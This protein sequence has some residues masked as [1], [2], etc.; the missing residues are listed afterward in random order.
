M[1]RA[2]PREILVAG[3]LAFM[4]YA[5][6]GYM[7]FDSVYQLGEARSGVF[8]DG[9][10]PAMAEL[11][12]LVDSVVAGPVGMLLIQSTCFLAGLY[13][14]FRRRMPARVSAFVA[15]GVLLFPP[16]TSLMAVIWKDSQ[17]T[18]FLVLGT[19]F[20]LDDNRR[21]KIAGLAFLVAGT[22]MRHNALVMT[23]PLVVMLFQWSAA[24]RFWKRHA[25]AL[26]AWIAVTGTAQMVSRA[27]TTEQR[28]IWVDSL[29]LCD[30]TSTLRYVPDTIP[31]A[32]LEAELAGT[33]VIP[34]HD[35]HVHARGQELG[36]PVDA[37]WNSAYAFFAIPKDEAERAAVTRAWRTIVF[38]HF[39]A[40][41]TY[42]LE[43]FRRVLGLIDIPLTSPV[44]NWFTDVQDP[45]GSGAKIGHDA[46]AGKL[47]NL[48]RE[49]IHIVGATYVFYVLVYV[50]LA[51]L[52]VPFAFRDRTVLALL[53]SAIFGEGIMFVIAP[54][55]DWRYSFWTILSV[56]LAIV[57]LVARRLYRVT[58][59]ED[60]EAVVGLAGSDPVR[61]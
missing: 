42:R 16:I 27:L 57:L 38:G 54:T 28:H 60:H 35:L 9:H 47:Q 45:W 52:L 48:L 34:T 49:G 21:R 15:I 46:A 36:A 22:A 44:Y 55:T 1:R 29:A 17:M 33:P 12:R 40:Y 2:T 7:S 53:V 39:G 10:P 11:W 6:P 4:V 50:V 31:D 3:W 58:D 14:L 13:L 43:V 32:Q 24:H 26:V 19:A 23:F 41:L 61:A 59:R 25:L 5:Y 37:L 18:A 56:V 20:M 30:I 8:S 51:L